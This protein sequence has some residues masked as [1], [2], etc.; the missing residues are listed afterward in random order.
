MNSANGIRKNSTPPHE[1]N[2]VAKNNPP[3]INFPKAILRF[4]D[5]SPLRNK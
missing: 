1:A 2:P 3:P 4:C 5:F